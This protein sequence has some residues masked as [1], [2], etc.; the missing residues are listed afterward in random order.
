[1]SAFIIRPFGVKQGIDFERVERELIDPVLRE[2]R[3]EGRTTKEIARAGNIRTDVFDGVLV[4]DL[5]IADISI[6]NANVYYELGIRHALRNR[7]TIL[8]RARSDEVPFDLE[9]DRYL[10]YS[11]DDP[12]A[13]KDELRKTIEQSLDTDA[14]DSP[15]FLLLPALEPVDPERFRPVP[16]AFTEAV[17]LAQTGHQRAR[18]ALLG[19]EIRGLEWALA[20]RRIVGS[21]QLE[22]SAWSDA[23]A[24]WESVRDERPNDLEANLKLGTVYQRLREPAESSAALD[25]VLA[26]TRLDAS[27]RA[28]VSALVGS[29]AKTRWVDEWRSL[30]PSKRRAAALGS[31]L[32]YDALKAYDEGYAADQNHFYSG[33][34]ALALTTVIAVLARNEPKAWKERFENDAEA[35]RE[36]EGIRRRREVLTASVGRTLEGADYR[37]QVTGGAY[38]VWVDL[39]WADYRLLTTKRPS[40]V[41]DAYATAR[42]RLAEGQAVTAPEQRQKFPAESAARQ[43]RIYLELGVRA[44][45]AKAA[46][47]ALG[48]PEEEP[49]VEPGPRPRLLVFSGHRIDAPGREVPRFPAGAE[50]EAREMIRAAVT[51]EKTLAGD[52]AVE[53]FAGGASGGDILFHEACAELGIPTTLMLAVP[54]DLYAKESVADAGPDW[55]ERFR[56]LCRRLPPQILGDTVELPDWLKSKPSYSVWQRSNLWTLHAPLSHDDADV[57]LIV[58]WDGKKGD[59]P[60]GTGDMVEIAQAR[61]VKVVR[62]DA[63]P[64]AAAQGA[65]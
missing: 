65:A 51:K 64:L 37:R 10:E 26:T 63:A 31:P 19:E 25:R 61:G 38:D 8:I 27:T 24:T 7:T 22:L 4:H 48:V 52:G 12:G 49:A 62:L 32:L 55:T 15:V 30:P 33:V 46:L 9:T 18:L 47:E 34:N 1:V 60:G 56:D 36:R 43:T 17:G 6:H 50:D 20:G 2:L 13:A 28:E 54:P 23:R 21:A 39:T 42:T 3:I 35:E 57:T 44:K 59:G 58:L 5:V 14:A 53:G 11:S 16:P 41:A 45:N 29:N 40:F